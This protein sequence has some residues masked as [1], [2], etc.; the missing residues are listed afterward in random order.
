MSIDNG[1]LFGVCG[2]MYIADA[3]GELWST[4]LGYVVVCMVKYS[5]LYSLSTDCTSP[6]STKLFN[7]QSLFLFVLS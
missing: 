4:F 7:S 3:G 6:N 2:V 1:K 5:E